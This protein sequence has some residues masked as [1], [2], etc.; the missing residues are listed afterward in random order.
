M[1]TATTNIW[2]S[3]IATGST[4]HYRFFTDA[5]GH[6]ELLDLALEPSKS[7][8]FNRLNNESTHPFYISDIGY[9]EPSSSRIEITGDGESSS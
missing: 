8:T 6:N 7:Y 5:T 4:P 9:A 2:V 1:A 3:T